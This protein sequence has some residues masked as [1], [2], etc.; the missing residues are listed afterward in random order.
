MELQADF[1][2]SHQAANKSHQ[3]DFK[4]NKHHKE[5]QVMLMVAKSGNSYFHARNNF[6][7]RMYYAFE[8]LVLAIDE[9]GENWQ[10]CKK[11]PFET[12]I[13]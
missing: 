7:D 11:A 1:I 12:D 2:G 10:R 3:G 9:C 8:D 5:P 6:M 13:Q 4:W